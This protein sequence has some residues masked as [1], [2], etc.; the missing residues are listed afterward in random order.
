MAA[1]LFSRLFRKV[2]PPPNKA[3]RASR[4]ARRVIDS[5][6]ELLSNRGEVSGA[7]VAQE[8]LNAYRDLPPGARP[9]FY[10]QLAIEFAPDPDALRAVCEAYVAMPTR[11]PCRRAQRSAGTR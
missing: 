3:A 7:A 2:V 9:A 6:Q 11:T 4:H 10:T 8:A 5:W 1:T